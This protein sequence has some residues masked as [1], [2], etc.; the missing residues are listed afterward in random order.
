VQLYLRWVWEAIPEAA[1]G[2]YNPKRSEMA[3][4]ARDIMPM[5]WL[6]STSYLCFYRHA[7][8]ITCSEKIISLEFFCNPKN[9]VSS[10]F[11]FALFLEKSTAKNQTI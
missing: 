1:F 9:N 11:L 4:I 8:G 6:L 7:F 2:I 10:K 3:W 5:L